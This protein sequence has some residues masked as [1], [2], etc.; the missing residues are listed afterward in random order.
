V[1]SGTLNPPICHS[2]TI[3]QVLLSTQQVAMDVAP[4]KR[5]DFPADNIETS[6]IVALAV[7]YNL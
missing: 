1:L 3:L 6:C 4:N 5:L 7:M 2:H